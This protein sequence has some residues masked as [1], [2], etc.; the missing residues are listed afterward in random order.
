MKLS[1]AIVIATV[2]L[3]MYDWLHHMACR[4]IAA[5]AKKLLARS[6]A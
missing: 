3:I 1:F 6:A 2:A 4:C 5:V